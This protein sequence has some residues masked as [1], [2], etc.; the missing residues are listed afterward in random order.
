[1]LHVCCDVRVGGCEFSSE[2]RRKTVDEIATQ[3]ATKA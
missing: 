3:L 2:Y 1:M